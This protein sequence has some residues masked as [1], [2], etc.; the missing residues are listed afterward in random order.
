MSKKR[1]RIEKRCKTGKKEEKYDQRQIRRIGKRNER[2]RK[3][4][5]QGK[6]NEMRWKTN[7]SARDEGEKKK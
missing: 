2:E 4:K 1:N 5:R 6:N 7:R 3:E